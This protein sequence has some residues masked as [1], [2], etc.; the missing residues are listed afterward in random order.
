[1][2]RNDDPFWLPIANDALRVMWY[3]V[4]AILKVAMSLRRGVV[5]VILF[6]SATNAYSRTPLV[7]PLLIQLGMLHLLVLWGD[8]ADC[9]REPLV[10]WWSTS[11]H[12]SELVA[13]ARESF[14]FSCVFK[15]HSVSSLV[16]LRCCGRTERV[17]QHTVN[18][19][20]H[21]AIPWRQPCWP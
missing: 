15:K 5:I 14:S 13:L 16:L 17:Q 18:N 6:S 7:Y 1:M 2:Y 9:E 11:V 21:L 8:D 4:S 10:A 3:I 19:V 20:C 12:P